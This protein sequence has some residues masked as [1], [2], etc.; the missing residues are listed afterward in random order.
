MATSDIGVE[1]LADVED[2]TSLLLRGRG[3]GER[4]DSTSSTFRHKRLE[5][6]DEHVEA[7]GQ[8]RLQRVVALD[9]GLVHAR[10]A[11]ARRRS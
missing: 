7:L 4:V 10:A 3:L 11:H 5:L 6:L 8:A 9:D 2:V 1:T